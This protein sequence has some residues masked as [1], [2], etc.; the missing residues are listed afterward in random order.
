[1]NDSRALLCPGP[2]NVQRP[3]FSLYLRALPARASL[4]PTVSGRARLWNNAGECYATGHARVLSL[5]PQPAASSWPHGPMPLLPRL[6]L[7]PQILWTDAELA[8]LPP[9]FVADVRDR[10]GLISFDFQSVLP[11]SLPPV[12]QWRTASESAAY[13][14]VAH[15]Q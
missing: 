13:C 2:I 14:T 11:V 7:P 4:H 6:P 10:L 9:R 3:L 12:A 8:L 15:C 1:V 5:D